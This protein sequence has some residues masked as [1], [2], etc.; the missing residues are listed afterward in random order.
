M[1]TSPSPQFHLTLLGHQGREAHMWLVTELGWYH[2]IPL[3]RSELDGVC[4]AL[5]LILFLCIYRRGRLSYFSLLSFGTLHSNGY[6]F[7]FLLCFSLPLF[8]QLF[9]RPPQTAILLFCI[10][11]SWGWSWSLPPLHCPEPPFIVLQALCV[12]N[13]IPWIYLSLPLYNHKR[14]GSNS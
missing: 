8:P 10:S 9:V 13:L 7:P 5:K 14:S 3:R 6:I 1:T 4:S 11:F 12:S 2:V